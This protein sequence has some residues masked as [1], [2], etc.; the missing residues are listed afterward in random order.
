MTRILSEMSPPR[1][2]TCVLFTVAVL[3]LFTA[4]HLGLVTSAFSGDVLPNHSFAC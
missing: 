3:N 4:F 2:S 1:P